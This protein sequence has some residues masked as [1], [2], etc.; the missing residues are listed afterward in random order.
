MDQTGVFP[1]MRTV[2]LGAVEEKDTAMPTE[3]RGGPFR[4][5]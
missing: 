3:R 5:N 2:Q 4:S 1:I